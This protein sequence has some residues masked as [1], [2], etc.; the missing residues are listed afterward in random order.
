M[1]IKL[2]H[3]IVPAKDKDASARFFAEMFGLEYAGAQGHFAPVRINDDTTLDFDDGDGFDHHHYAFLITD[4][5]FDGIYSRVKA[6]GIPYGSG[7][8]HPD[9]MEVNTRRDGRGFYFCDPNGHLLEV[10][11]RA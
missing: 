10:M 5:Q 11:T 3:T 4:E 7:P 1:A 6:A 8:R 2:N 9:N